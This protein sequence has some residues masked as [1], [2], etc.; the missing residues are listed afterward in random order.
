[1]SDLSR[2]RHLLVNLLTK[3]KHVLN[4]S[5]IGLRGSLN[6]ARKVFLRGTPAANKLAKQIS[7]LLFAEVPAGEHLFV[8]LK[9]DAQGVRSP[10]HFI[11]L[12]IRHGWQEQVWSIAV[13]IVYYL[14]ILLR[15]PLF[16]GL[17]AGGGAGL[18]F[19]QAVLLLA[20]SCVAEGLVCSFCVNLSVRCQTRAQLLLQTAL[21]KKVTCLSAS[22]IA[23]N[24]SGFVSTLLIADAWLVSLYT[25]FLANAGVGLLCIPVVLSTLAHEMGYE[26]ACACLVWIAAVALA[27]TV[28]V[29]LLYNS[30]RV[31]YRFRD[32]RLKKFTDFLLSIRPIK[33]SALEGVFQDSLLHLRVKEINQAYRVN[34]LEILLETLFSA[35]S[36]LMIIIAFGTVSFTKPDA[37]FSPAV[38]FSCV[39]MLTIMDTL[40]TGAPHVLRLKSSLFRSCRR[41][42]SFFKE[43]EYSR[44]EDENRHSP[45][46]TVGE[47]TLKDCS[48]AWAKRDEKVENPALDAISLLV[49]RGSL[50][51]IVGPVGSGKSSLLSAIV[52]DMRHLSGTVSVNGSIGIVS[53]APQIL[54]MTIRDNITFGRKFEE[55]YYAKVVEA[56]QLYRDINMMPAGDL[57][58]A[59]D[60]GEMLSGGQKQRVA[61]AR[62][63]YSCSDIYLLDDP[64]SSQDVRV[65]HSIV[66]QVLAHGGLL[67]N[68][69]RV[70][71][72]NNLSLPLSPNQWVLM[73][74]KKGITF[75]DFKE[76]KDHPDA[77]A[78]L[79]ENPTSKRLPE[80]TNSLKSTSQTFTNPVP[81]IMWLHILKF[82]YF[83]HFLVEKVNL[84]LTHCLYRHSEEHL[85]ESGEQMNVIKEE[86]MSS[87]GF[88][89]IVRAYFKYSGACAPVALLSLAASAVF[90]ACQ[91]L[92]IKA[93]AA[94]MISDTANTTHS[95]RSIIRWL[96]VFCI[97]DVILRL[98]GGT[99]LARANHHRSLK[100]H[101]DMLERVAGSALS[102]FDA[103]PRGR[104][105]NRFATDLEIN[106]TRVFMFFKQFLQNLL[107]VFARLAVIGTQVPFVF[108]LTVCAEVIL[109]FCMRYLIRA[110][111][112]GRLYESTQL[113]RVLQHLTETLECVGLMRCYGVMERFCARF[114]RMLNTYLESFNLFVYCFAIG[115]LISTICALVVIVLTVAIIVAPARDDPGA[116]AMAGLSLLSAFTVP[117]ATVVVFLGGFWNATGDAAFQRTLEYT[118]LPLEKEVLT[119]R[120]DSTGH[121]K[122]E[123]PRIFVQPYD[124]LWPSKGV[125]S[126]ENFSASYRPGIT[127]DTL[128]GISFVA[129]AG[130]KLAIVGRTGAGKS[131]LVLALLRMIQRTSGTITIDGV[132][133]HTVPLNRLRTVISVIPQD[134]SMF[135]GTL[136]ENLDPQGS[137]SDEVLWRVLRN[138]HLSDFVETT[139]EGLSF[140]VSQKGE[141]LSAGQRQLVALAR[142]LLRATKILVL[143]EA[144][145][146][147]DSDTERRVQAS[148][149]ESFAHCTVITIAHRIDT[150]LDYDRVVVMGDGRVLEFGGVRELLTNPCS[151]FRSIVTSA[152]IDVEKRISNM[153]S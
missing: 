125:V 25:S 41:L 129:E 72:T 78:E 74:A 11:W 132:D 116:A 92:C 138:V 8:G 118:E 133:I 80:R 95:G 150:I 86:G 58:E 29:P 134:Y 33:M 107:Y 94:T 140:S 85:E 88:F 57:T 36:T 143:D 10:Y 101:A 27:C 93:W 102:F 142:A 84:S 61:L 73:H 13:A 137:H 131:S 136:R 87:K 126:F 1:M 5:H 76:L 89:E 3:R 110:T 47:V 98:A 99:L 66:Q 22:G 62:A 115:R 2:F 128:K 19:N 15:I 117:F 149:R 34:I 112:Y 82:S 50:V 52:G 24:P 63:V 151:V 111:M 49:E 21:F 153:T 123:S 38:M 104:I 54:N 67:T 96:A 121:P 91:M 114:R 109:L 39:Y 71:V 35:S 146:Q 120:K 113:S 43:E 46:V 37:T 59:G 79:F 6:S 53:Q 90:V 145:S 135:T 103:T 75:R 105:F 4:I 12:L 16:Q 152:G 20:A 14:S 51:G 124:D 65:A 23:A 77:P 48:F 31:L 44:V 55:L 119:E 70:L 144:T 122:H 147:M 60:K 40:A 32:E 106:D 83:Q 18:S 127:D 45:N 9:P 7:E 17:L 141:N 97:G 108:G 28:I 42:I 68:R 56:C 81:A 64:T 139:P 148:L 69:T 26:P 30:C 100:L 130:Q